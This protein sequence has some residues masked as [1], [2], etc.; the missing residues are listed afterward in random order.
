ACC[1]L[2]V[3]TQGS[4]RWPRLRATDHAPRNSPSPASANSCLAVNRLCDQTA[5]MIRTVVILSGILLLAAGT[6]LAA[7][8]RDAKVLSD[9]KNVQATG[10]WIYN[11]L[12]NAIDQAGR[13]G[14]PL[15]V[16]FR[17]VP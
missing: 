12:T 6:I 11:D 16:V 2:R 1:A 8:D 15:L 4:G 5:L 17:C 3:P 7:E 9:R 14:R 13:T 10:N